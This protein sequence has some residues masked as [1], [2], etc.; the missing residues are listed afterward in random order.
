MAINISPRQLRDSILKRSLKTAMQDHQVDCHHLML[1]VTEGV[2]VD[3]VDAALAYLSDLS[4]EGIQLA[5]DDFGTGYSSLSYLKTFPFNR[6]KIDRSFVGDVL[7]DSEGETL[8]RV[9]VDLAH[10]FG[11]TVVAEGVESESQYRFLRSI[12]VDSFQGYYFSPPL[13]AV[14]FSR[15]LQSNLASAN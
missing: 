6:L 13:S 2:L 9:M 10:K 3:N 8:V 12:G 5:I 14:E 15:L 1:E 4:A 11:M 7:K